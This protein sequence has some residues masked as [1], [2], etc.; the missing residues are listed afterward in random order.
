MTRQKLPPLAVT[1]LVRYPLIHTSSRR[2]AWPDWLCAHG[3]T[4]PD[5]EAPSHEFGHF[6]MSLNAAKRG[7]GIALLPD[8]IL[9]NESL[10]DSLV[11]PVPADIG[12]AGDYALLVPDSDLERPTVEA[13]RSWLLDECG[14]KQG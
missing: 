7:Q 5:Q 10:G 4:P 1:D 2:F 12:S 13:F 3:L 9:Q 14:R 8:I 11:I 6:F